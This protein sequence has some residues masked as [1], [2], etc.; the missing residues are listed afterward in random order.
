MEATREACRREERLGVGEDEC[1]TLVVGFPGTELEAAEAEAIFADCA[2][3][4]RPGM[5]I[6]KGDELGLRSAAS[7]FVEALISG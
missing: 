2:I 4:D 6:L 5:R 1:T 7:C 3:C